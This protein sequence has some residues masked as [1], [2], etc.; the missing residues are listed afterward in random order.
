VLQ[1]AR[2]G[3]TDTAVGLLDA[4]LPSSVEFL[5]VLPADYYQYLPTNG[6]SYVQGIGMHQEMKLFGQ[7]LAFGASGQVN[8]NSRETAPYG[9]GTNWNAA[10]RWGD[11]SLPE[12]VLIG[13]QLV[14]VTQHYFA[15]S[16][17]NLAASFEAINQQMHYLSTNNHLQTDYRL[18]PASLA[19]WQRI[20]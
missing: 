2:V 16:G 6:T 4:D 20:R 19:N 5:P 10:L 15:G 13:N 17:P 9:L 12:R 3:A 18:T 8:W 1:G 7:P 11:S 14:L